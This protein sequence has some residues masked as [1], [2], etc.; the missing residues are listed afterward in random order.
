MSLALCT[1]TSTHDL[2]RG[3]VGDTRSQAMIM[4]GM[5]SLWMQRNKRRHGEAPVPTKGA[6]QWVADPTF[7]LWHISQTPTVTTQKTVN[8]GWERRLQYAKAPVDFG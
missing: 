3:R 6:V 8:R 5:Y 4:I 2:V 7:D 1:E